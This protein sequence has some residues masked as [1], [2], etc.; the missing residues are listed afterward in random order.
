MEA[1]VCG[2]FGAQARVAC[3][4]AKGVCLIV[5][6]VV[7]WALLKSQRVEVGGGRVWL[8]MGENEGWWERWSVSMCP[9]A[10]GTVGISKRNFHLGQVSMKPQDVVQGWAEWR[11]PTH[12]HRGIEG[13]ASR[14]PDSVCQKTN[15]KLSSYEGWQKYDVLINLPMIHAAGW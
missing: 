15:Q 5:I 8:R 7:L 4:R 11:R 6:T 12:R 9:Y 10:A 14:L 3:D 1:L 2:D 13:K